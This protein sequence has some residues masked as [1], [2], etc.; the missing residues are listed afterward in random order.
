MVQVGDANHAL[1]EI[2]EIPVLHRHVEEYFGLLMPGAV[3]YGA[4]ECVQGRRTHF[5]FV[6]KQTQDLVVGAGKDGLQHIEQTSGP[7]Y[8]PDFSQCLIDQIQRD[9][10]Q[11]LQHQRQVELLSAKRNGLRSGLQEVQAVLRL[12]QVLGVL[13]LVDFQS[14]DIASREARQQAA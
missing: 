4:V 9:V 7:Q 8:A 12:C 1:L 11:G 3:C 13:A 5:F 10:V 2:G 14:I 6:V